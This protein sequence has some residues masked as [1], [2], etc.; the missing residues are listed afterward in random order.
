MKKC[1]FCRLCS[2]PAFVLWAVNSI[3][4]V[5]QAGLALNSFTESLNAAEGCVQGERHVL[6]GTSACF[7]ELGFPDLKCVKVLR[8]LKKNTFL[9]LKKILRPEL[10]IKFPLHIFANYIYRYIC[11]SN[12]Q[13]LILG[14]N[15]VQVL[16]IKVS[17]S[18][19]EEKHLQDSCH[20]KPLPIAVVF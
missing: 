16:L 10:H 7:A 15:F 12:I 13:I 4:A 2:S 20:T 8:R 5:G 11:N 3:P 14:R 9:Y 1:I 18:V 6:K 17:K 19:F